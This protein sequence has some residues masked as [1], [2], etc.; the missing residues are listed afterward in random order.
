LE[1]IE[2]LQYHLNLIDI[3]SFLFQIK[4]YNLPFFNLL[5]KLKILKKLSPKNA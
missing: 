4:K 1:H 2:L 3:F 5:K